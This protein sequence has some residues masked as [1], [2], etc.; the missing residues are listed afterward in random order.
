MHN[1]AR[2]APRMTKN[3]PASPMPA[4]VLLFR[5][6]YGGVSPIVTNY[7]GIPSQSRFTQRDQSR[8]NQLAET[9]RL[10]PNI[11]SVT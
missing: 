10:T 4:H 5:S 6:F 3:R 1:L 8:K 2:T 7:A 11:K 9:S